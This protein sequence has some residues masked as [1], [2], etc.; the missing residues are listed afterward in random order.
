VAHAVDADALL[1][2]FLRGVGPLHQQ[3]GAL[4]PELMERIGM[5]LRA[6]TDGTLQ[7][8]LARQELKRE[9]R[10]EVTMIAA[11][12]NNPLKFSPTAD[13]ALAHLLGPAIRGFMPPEAAMH[14]AYDDLRAHQFGVMVG[15]RAALAQLIE[16]FSPQQLERKIAARSA[17]EHVFS[18]SR[19]ARL[20]EQFIALYATIA[21]E[22]EE[23]FQTLFGKA[24]AQAYDEQIERLKRSG[25]ANGS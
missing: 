6:A 15:M 3:P 14:D 21:Q 8:L 2:A 23:D 1:A 18:A 12:A 4:T 17:L 24:F 11:Q 10:A 25:G 5:L 20:W 19:K 9:V 16:R 7:L 13:V 22:A